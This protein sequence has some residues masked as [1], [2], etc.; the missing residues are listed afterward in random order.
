M[1]CLGEAYFMAWVKPLLNEL[2]IHH[3]LERV[4]RSLLS[5]YSDGPGRL[6]NPSGEHA[7]HVCQGT[8]SRDPLPQNYIGQFGI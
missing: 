3:R 5:F 7:R 6:C 1:D 8:L 4:F 2:S